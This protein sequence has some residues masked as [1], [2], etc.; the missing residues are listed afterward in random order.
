MIVVTGGAGFIGSAIVWK[1]NQLGKTN[2]IVVDELGKSEKW[3][4]LVGLRYEDFV[5]K[6]EFIEQILDDV[7][8][9]N[10]EAIIHMGANSSTT[11]KDADHLMDN[12][13]HYTKEL[14]KYCVEKN[15]RF[16][17]A[18]SAATYGDGTLGFDDDESK[19]ET[20]RPLNMYGYSKHLFD[21]WA[22]RN[23]ILNRIVGL[24]YFNVYGSNEYHKGDMRSVVHKAFEQI[25][26]TGKVRLFKSLNAKYKDGE[27]MRDFVYVK[28]AVDMTLYF[29]DN[30]NINGLFN[31]GSG[32]ARTWNDLIAALFNAVGK[33]VNIEYIDLPQ[34]LEDKY[35]YF[36]E[37]NLKK[38]NAAGYNR[39]TSAL[40]D[41]VDDYVKN[42]LLKAGY[43]GY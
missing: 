14:A 25:R 13:F 38:I 39:A 42:Y 19:L 29:L 37:A 17:Y 34:H 12:N 1:L 31:V 40:E 41:G 32:K 3:K 35:Q 4:N 26:D 30:Q 15:I 28:D 10:V 20:L 8:P 21:L 22:K 43:L 5:N 23:H 27:Q 33:P 18:S 11:E 24:K 9:Y 7:I 2:I 36:T 6:L 16:I